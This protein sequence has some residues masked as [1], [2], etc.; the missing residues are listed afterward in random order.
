VLRWEPDPTQEP[1]PAYRGLDGEAWVALVVPMS[2]RH[3]P[4]RWWQASRAGALPNGKPAFAAFHTQAEAQDWCE[5]THTVEPLAPPRPDAY[6]SYG[7]DARTGEFT[8]R[9]CYEV[10]ITPA[11]P[12]AAEKEAK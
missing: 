11:R 1:Q 9:W 4:W 10:G 2:S 3:H 7:I 8:M 12:A 6:L 5:R